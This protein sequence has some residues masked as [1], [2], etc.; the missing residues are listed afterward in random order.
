M[1]LLESLVRQADQ[2]GAS[3]LHL[4]AGLP[5]ML[6]VNGQL[7]SVEQPVSGRELAA[8]AAALLHGEA[9]DAFEQ[10]RSADLSR[11]LAGVRCRLNVFYS[12]RG[13][14]FAVRLLHPFQATLETLNLHPDVGRLAQ[15]PHGLL[16]VSGPTGSGKSSTIAALIEEI[17]R[18]RASHVVTLWSG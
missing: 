14:S 8:E 1:S 15:R 6:R 7:R 3:D 2:L 11:T 10:R 17:N 5:A 16:V 18:T 9:W 13:V 4:E 12:A